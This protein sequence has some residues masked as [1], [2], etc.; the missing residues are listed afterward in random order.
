MARLRTWT[1]SAYGP[2]GRLAR[3]APDFMRRARLADEGIGTQAWEVAA[4]LS[5]ITHSLVIGRA[6]GKTFTGTRYVAALDGQDLTARQYRAEFRDFNR[7]RDLLAAEALIA[8]GFEDQS[9][10]NDTCPIFHHAR[11]GL[12]VAV[13]FEVEVR[14]EFP[15]CSRLSVWREGA[16]GRIDREVLFEGDDLADLLAWLRDYRDRLVRWSQG[17]DSGVERLSGFLA[18]NADG[19]D[20]AE[21]RRIA[22]EVHAG[23]TYVG[24]GGA[25]AEFEV[26]RATDAERETHAEEVL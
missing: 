7:A 21:A 6:R 22:W 17:T 18:A 4:Q 10:H 16:D 14:R 3:Q 25:A 13:D 12:S 26:R 24:G 9:W 15:D 2:E 11:D 20:D 8:E 23:R 1:F 5:R 19:I